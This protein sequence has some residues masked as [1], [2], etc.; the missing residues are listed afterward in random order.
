MSPN[1]PQEIRALA[2]FAV[3]LVELFARQMAAFELLRSLDVDQQKI[4]AATL[5]AHDQLYR[6]PLIANLRTQIDA[7]QLE[8]LERL[9]LTFRLP[10]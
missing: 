7:P 2:P 4:D 10:E 1:N 8:L 9:L 6:I 5:R 3:M